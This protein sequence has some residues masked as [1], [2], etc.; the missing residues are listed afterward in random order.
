MYVILR[1]GPYVCAEWDLGGHPYWFLKEKENI[2]RTVDPKY[3]DAATQ[4]I[5]SVAEQIKDFQITQNGTI[6]ML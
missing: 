6:I 3:I 1:P 4:Y 5:Y 2:M